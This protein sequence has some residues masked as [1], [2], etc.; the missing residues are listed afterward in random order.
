MFRLA[1]VQPIAHPPAEAQAN[2]ADAVDH[3]ARAAAQGAHF[4]CF[5]ETYPGPWRLPATFDPT[6]AM[7][8]AAAQHGVHVVFGTIEPIAGTS[9]SAHNLICMAYPDGRPPARYRR[10]SPS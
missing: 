1:I 4:V 5:P 3:V 9:A 6:E 8:Q 10:S 2:V 7:V